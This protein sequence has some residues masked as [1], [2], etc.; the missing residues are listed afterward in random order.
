ME[1]SVPSHGSPSRIFRLFNSTQAAVR[2]PPIKNPYENKENIPPLL[3]EG[4]RSSTA[5][6]GPV[7]LGRPS[8]QPYRRTELSSEDHRNQ[9]GRNVMEQVYSPSFIAAGSL[10]DQGPQPDEQLPT[11]S[12]VHVCRSTEL[13]TIR[14]CRSSGDFPLARSEVLGGCLAENH[15]STPSNGATPGN[16]ATPIPSGRCS[17]EAQ[18]ETIPRK[19]RKRDQ[20]MLDAFHGITE[21]CF[22]TVVRPTM[23]LLILTTL[24]L[25]HILPH[26][27]ASPGESG[28]ARSTP[29]PGIGSLVLLGGEEGGVGYE[30]LPP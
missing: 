13:P 10:A 3:P 11:I 12:K 6:R 28:H 22:K 5:R 27:I 2:L 8:R 14:T 7:A 16:A 25:S 15:P 17:I 4:R 21:V 26:C 24:S 29:H 20:V 30:R 1:K 19:R 18:D 23:V 9:S